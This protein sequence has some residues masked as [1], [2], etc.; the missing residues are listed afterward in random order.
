LRKESWPQDKEGIRRTIPVFRALAESQ[1]DNHRYYGQLGFALKDQSPPDCRGAEEALTQAIT[2]RGPERRWLL[3]EANRAFCWI[4]L[5]DASSNK[6]QPS[7]PDVQNKIR[8]DLVAVA[9]VLSEELGWNFFEDETVAD[10]MKRN[11]IKFEE[12]R[13]AGP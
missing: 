11:G 12:L 4:M 1:K 3:Y 8:A 13:Q 7:S 10:W 5:D 2:L 9:S 6:K